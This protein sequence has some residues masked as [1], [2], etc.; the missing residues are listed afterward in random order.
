MVT[1]ATG[2]ES[3]TVQV[4]GIRSSDSKPTMLSHKEIL[5]MVLYPV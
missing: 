2:L 4:A 5:T 1:G 3:M